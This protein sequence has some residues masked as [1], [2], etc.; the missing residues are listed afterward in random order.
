VPSSIAIV[1]PVYN[2]PE[3]VVRAIESVRPQLDGRAV[4]VIVD[5]GSTDETP[6][7]LE[8]YAADPA[9]RLLR[10]PRNRGVAAA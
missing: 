5:D 3:Q 6:R 9:F 2:R 10:H 8:R 1:V 4:V 7:V